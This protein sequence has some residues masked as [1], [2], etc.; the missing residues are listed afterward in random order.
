MERNIAESEDVRSKDAPSG[1]RKH[2]RATTTSSEERT[3]TPYPVHHAVSRHAATPLPSRFPHATYRD[4][5]ARS[6]DAHSRRE[7]PTGKV[8]RHEHRRR[9]SAVQRSRILSQRYPITCESTRL[10]LPPM[11]L[12]TSSSLKPR[13]SSASVAL[14]NSSHVSKP[15]IPCMCS[16]IAPQISG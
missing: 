14:G 12:R 2:W 11:I 5:R 3:I 13:F 16:S 9:I 10:K 1:V 15:L 4:H 6:D 8:W 7:S